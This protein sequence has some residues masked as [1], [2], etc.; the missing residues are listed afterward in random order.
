[1]GFCEYW[2]IQVGSMYAVVTITRAPNGMFAWGFMGETHYHHGLA[3][4]LYGAKQ[5]ARKAA[6]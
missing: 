3:D 4:T 6:E 1:M 5:A 2:T